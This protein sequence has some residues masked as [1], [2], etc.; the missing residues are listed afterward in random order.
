MLLVKEQGNWR[1]DAHD[2]FVAM[3]THTPGTASGRANAVVRIVGA[4]KVDGHCEFILL[5]E[6]AGLVS[7]C[8]HRYTDFRLL[9]EALEHGTPFPVPKR[10]FHSA[11]VVSE[12]MTQLEHYLCDLLAKHAGHVPLPLREFLCPTTPD[13]DASPTL[14][15][16]ENRRRPS[17][18]SGL[19]R[20]RSP[21]MGEA[22]QSPVLPGG[23]VGTF[24]C[25]GMHAVSTGGLA[26]PK[27]NQDRGSVCYPFG[28]R[29]DMAL[30]CVFDGHGPLGH[31]VAELAVTRVPEVL[32]GALRAGLAEEQ[33]LA[34]AFEQVD[35]ELAASPIDS[36][37]SGTTGLALLYR[38][39]SPARHTLWTA[40]AG[41]S[42]ATV[43]MSVDGRMRVE[44]LTIDQ[45]PDDDVEMVRDS[46]RGVAD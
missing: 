15:A 23:V 41:D 3:T 13:G 29:G 42:R 7:R 12:R 4:K 5:V 40:C 37:L 20:S 16:S 1:A 28:T 25:C 34:T 38:F 11:S 46:P 2:T 21:E 8:Q 6:S 10:I 27:V 45:K 39:D 32:S 30:F 44:D 26:T 35:T 19:Y 18:A 17:M 22:P 43:R 24:S 36:E 31:A 14:A 9:H 33:A